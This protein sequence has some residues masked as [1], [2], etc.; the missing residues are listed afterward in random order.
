MPRA[1]IAD[2]WSQQAQHILE[3][4]NGAQRQVFE[5]AETRAA[6]LDMQNSTS[7]R[8]TRPVR[9]VGQRLLQLRLL[10]DRLRT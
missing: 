4:E 1:Q 7:W 9:F 10:V 8:L 6:L 3:I 5:L 2:K